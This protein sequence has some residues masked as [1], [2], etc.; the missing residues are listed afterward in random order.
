LFVFILEAYGPSQLQTPRYLM[1]KL[2]TKI[3][4]AWL[5]KPKVF[6]DARGFF[7]RIVEP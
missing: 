3:N 4:D 2:P 5:L 1:K 7:P 6:G